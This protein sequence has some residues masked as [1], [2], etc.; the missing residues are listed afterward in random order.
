MMQK[1]TLPKLKKEQIV[2]V[3]LLGLLLMVLAIPTKSSSKEK[4]RSIESVDGNEALQIGDTFEETTYISGLEARLEDCLSR[5]RGVGRVKVLITL[6]SSPEAVL[7]KD[8]KGSRS[9]RAGEGQ[10]E[11]ESQSEEQTVY[12]RMDQGETPYVV[13]EVTPVVKGVLVVA[14][15]GDDPAVKEQI[16]QAVMALFSVESHKIMIVKMKEG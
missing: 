12:D 16:S 4:D 13:K 1:R 8:S 11:T 5:I 10:Q 9:T 7:A 6:K 14:D 15:G 2:V 3:F